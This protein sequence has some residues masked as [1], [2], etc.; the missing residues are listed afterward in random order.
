MRYI[1]I[2]Y[3]MVSINDIDIN[4]YHLDIIRNNIIYVSEKEMLFDGSLYNNICLGKDI[5][6]KIFDKVTKLLKIDDICNGNYDMRIEDGGFNLS[7]GERQRVIL[8]RSIL[9]EREVYIFDESFN[10][11]DIKME[12]LLLQISSIFNNLVTLSNNLSSTFL[13]NVIFLYKLPENNNSFSLT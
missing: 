1:L 13:F 4:H 7:S 2:D 3:G 6:S 12:K 8:C 11:L 10:Q 5:D 9:I